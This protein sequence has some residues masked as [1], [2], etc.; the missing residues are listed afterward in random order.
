VSFYCIKKKSKEPNE[1]KHTVKSV[2]NLKNN[3]SNKIVINEL[4]NPFKKIKKME[5]SQLPEDILKFDY[6]LS[7]LHILILIS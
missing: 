6:F 4:E 5:I 7:K 2:D 3:T 1:S